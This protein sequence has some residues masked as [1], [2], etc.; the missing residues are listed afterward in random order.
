[1]ENENNNLENNEIK[2]NDSSE[3]VNEQSIENDNHI[4]NFISKFTGSKY[5]VAVFVT[6]V[7]AAICAFL[8]IAETSLAAIPLIAS[9]FTVL[10]CAANAIYAIDINGKN[11]YR[12]DMVAAGG[13]LLLIGYI[14]RVIQLGIYFSPQY[15]I[16]YFL[17]CIAFV[18][19]NIKLIKNK[20][21]T[22]FLIIFF[23]VLALYSVFEFFH[24][25]I[26]LPTMGFMWKFYHITEA[27]VFLDYIFV[28]LLHDSCSEEFENGIG[29][30]KTQIPSAKICIVIL[31]FVSAIAFGIGCLTHANEIKLFSSKKDDTDIETEPVIN[32]GTKP[33]PNKT[34]PDDATKPV[35]NTKVITVGEN[36]TIDDVCKF[37][38]DYID[39]TDNVAPPKNPDDSYYEAEDGKVY[40]DFCIAYNNMSSG[41]VDS[42]DV[43]S[44]KLIYDDKYEYNGFPIAEAENREY[45][46]SYESIS[47]LT[48]EY[49]H[50]LFMIPEEIENSDAPIELRMQIGGENYKVMAR[51]ELAAKESAGNPNDASG[52]GIPLEQQNELTP[53][54]LDSV[55]LEQPV[56]VESTKYVVQDA[57]YKSLYPDMLQAVIRNNS[58]TDVKNLVI[59]FVAWDKNNLPV[60]IKGDIDFSDGS[61]VKECN[62][63]D[64]NIPN[65]KTYGDQSGMEIDETCNITTFK[66]IVVS[67]DDFD[68]NTWNNSYYDT[69]VDFYS[70][71]KLVLPATE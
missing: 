21:N 42:D 51:D 4:E 33:S 37:T 13:A 58:G 57:R 11:K 27:L 31:L 55:L 14:L 66:A 23:G 56:Y 50:Y 49:V 70:D 7:V 8:Y 1:M 10:A 52:S 69:W 47:P 36:V 45:L 5:R 26:S 44:G 60:K 29:K 25:N 71:K 3:T 61:Y 67:Y 38:F 22:K 63:N 18:L 62:Y 9:M 19:T 32:A 54:E 39:I 46:T 64:V 40:L 28:L 65:G 53:E 30:Y 68:G 12:F 43:M 20:G 6:S 2:V 48:T 41:S 15:F 17:F 59:A 35:D 16:A 34:T 24:S